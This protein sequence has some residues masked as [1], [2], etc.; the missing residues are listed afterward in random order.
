M[1][2][3]KHNSRTPPKKN[4]SGGNFHIEFKSDAQKL[5]WAAFQQHD[6]LFLIGPAGVGKSH[7]ACAFAIEQL[8]NK[9]KK[10]ITITRPIVE[11]GESLGFLPGEFTDKVYPYMLPI[12]DCLDRIVGRDNIFRE[13]VNANLEIA[14]LA[15]LRGRTLHDSVCILDEAQNATKMQLKMFLSRFGENSKVI[16]TGDPSQS[17]LGGDDVALMDVMHRLQPITGVGVVQFKNNSIIRHPL[18]SEILKQL[19]T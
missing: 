11:A 8:L 1:T 15:Y 3:K 19:E 6:V 10:K 12:Y 18:V 2:T 14:P 9:T 4:N 5:A 13:K 17:D 16:V 7:L